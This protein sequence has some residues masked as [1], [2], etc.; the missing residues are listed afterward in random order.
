MTHCRFALKTQVVTVPTGSRRRHAESYA[1]VVFILP[2]ETV[3]IEN[4]FRVM[5]CNKNKTRS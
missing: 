1:A 3:M 2:F 4:L 5:I